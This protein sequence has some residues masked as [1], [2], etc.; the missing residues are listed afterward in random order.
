MLFEFSNLSIILA[1]CLGIPASHLILSWLCERIPRHYFEITQTNKSSPPSPFYTKVLHIRSWKD[2]LPTAPRWISPFSKAQISS[3]DNSYLQSFI[4]ETRRGELSH[5]LQ[6]GA[7]SL[8][9]LWT[10]FPASLI[11][12]VYAALS[13]APCI[14]NLRYTR[15]RLIKLQRQRVQRDQRADSRPSARD[16]IA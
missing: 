2:R 13:N 14:L 15:Q 1:N 7:I 12:L 16:E 9:I 3:L 6:W 5:W 11:I 4:S 10:P 8:F